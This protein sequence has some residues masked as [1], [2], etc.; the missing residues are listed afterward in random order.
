MVLN[1]LKL[2]QKLPLMV[3]ALMALAI[4]AM[5]IVGMTA[6]KSLIRQGALEKLQSVAHIQASRVHVFMEAVER[7][8]LLQ[9]RAQYTIG[10]LVDLVTAYQ[11]MDDASDVLRRVFIEENEYPAGQKDLLVNANTGSSYG[12]RHRDLHPH[13]HALQTDND[14]YDIFLFDTE[15]NLVYSVFKEDDFATNMLTGPWK[16]SGLAKAYRQALE[17]GPKEPPVFIDFLPYGPS[18]FA[19]AAFVAMPVFEGEDGNLL[20]VIAYQMPAGQLSNVVT[21]LDGLGPTSNGYMVGEDRLLRTD[22]VATEANEILNVVV[23]NEGVTNGLDNQEGQS[24]GIG[25]N[26]NPAY[27]AYAPLE[28]RGLKWVV[29]VEQDEKAIMSGLASARMSNLITGFIVFAIALFASLLFSRRIILP[30][31]HLTEAVSMVADG[32]LDSTIPGTD[33]KDEVGALARAAETFRQNALEMETLNAAQAETNEKMSKLTQEREEAAQREALARKD[34]EEK[35]RAALEQRESMMRQLDASFGQLVDAATMGDFQHRV[36]VDFDDAV[37]VGLADK[38]NA[39]MLS[40]DTGLSRAGETLQRIAAGDLTREMQ[41]DFRGAFADLQTNMNDMLVS[42]REL[43]AGLSNS[44]VSLANSSSH[45]TQTARDLSS[46]AER[47]AASLEQT[48]ASAEEISK[49]FTQVKQNVTDSSDLARRARETARANETVAAEAVA[50]MENIAQ[51]SSEIEQVV[52]VIEGITFQINLLA[53]NAGVEAA[54]AGD[55]GRGFSVVASEVR[56]L[57]QRSSE[58]ANEITG[59][60]GRTNGAV[61]NGVSKVTAAKSSLDQIAETILQIASSI[62]DA[63]VMIA[64]QSSGISE[65]TSAIAQVDSATQRQV[66]SFEEITAASAI[67]SDQADELK[68][69]ASDFKVDD[70]D[71]ASAVA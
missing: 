28:F 2:K 59:V 45:L 15:G 31:Q 14:Y 36:N 44:S 12:F 62:D 7:D 35:D 60:I 56:A 17:R 5:A 38:M 1:D 13:F 20:G 16:D 6:T 68:A 61:S 57:A 19:P 58:A 29:F 10:A 67:L 65:I 30:V 53:L 48:S 52:S 24:I 21:D 69:A 27:S 42:L 23:D 64:E 63:A 50:S 47:N 37:L 4:G 46:E 26:G 43:I 18:E 25:L 39:L 49:S 55:A 71:D 8:L 51:A 32:Q 11:A 40:V 66:A 41:G 54:R 3:A 22:L 70:T 9:A 34:Q 33:R